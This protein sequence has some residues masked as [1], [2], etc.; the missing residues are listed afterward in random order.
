[1]NLIFT[2]N[3]TSVT[4]VVIGLGAVDSTRPAVTIA[5]PTSTA[6]YSATSSPMALGGT[7]SDNVGVTK[8]TWTND[9]G[10][11]G[12][13][14][15][16]TSW[17]ASG[18]AL[19]PGAN[20]LTVTARDAAGNTAAATLTVTLSDTTPPTVALTAPTAGA[21]VTGALSVTATA[22][23]N[24]GVAG[25]QFKLDGANLGAERTTTPYSV[26]WDTTTAAGGSHTLTA[27]RAGCGRQF[28][29]VVTG[30]THRGRARG[31]R[32]RGCAPR[33][34]SD[35]RRWQ[36]GRVERSHR[37]PVQRAVEPRDGLSPLGRHEPVRGLPGQRQP[38]ERHPHGAG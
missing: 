11:S 30:G 15:G 20:V 27:V 28:H 19:Q 23:D 14:V 13:A 31:G 10:G 8:V 1:V 7:A 2:A 26:S 25:V 4:R 16:T 12:T 38:A 35:H 6:A 3:G 29:D 34:F 37:R 17:T 36:S 24:V 21:T 33:R 22:T 18:I 32:A 9:R 5:T